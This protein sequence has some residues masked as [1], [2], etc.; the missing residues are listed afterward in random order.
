MLTTIIIFIIVFLIYLHWAEQYK[1]GEDLEIYEIDFTDNGHLQEVCK[2]K[3]PIVC[4]FSSV[5]SKFHFLNTISLDD[6]GDK[7][8]K[9]D[10]YVKDTDDTGSCDAIPLSLES[11]LKLMATDT[12]SH[13]ISE[14][15]SEFIDET[16]LEKYYDS[17]HEYIK[18]AFTIHKQ[19]DLC[20][21]SKG[22]S[23]PLRYNT[24]FSH[25]MYVPKGK[26]R[27]KMT[28]H[29]SKKYLHPIKDYFSYEFY[30]PVCVWNTQ[31]EYQ[32][33]IDKIQ[34][35]DF[36]VY[37][38]NLLF[39]PPYW[40]FSLQYEE[41]GTFLYSIKYNTLMNVIANTHNIGNY[42]FQQY[43]TKTKP[44]KVLKI[45]EREIKTEEINIPI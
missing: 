4:E 34:F 29:K 18:P 41:E 12:H 25:F 8:G 17:L 44:A 9:L 38:G 21:G 14:G 27:V 26:I 16:V 32:N 20:Y 11:S 42:L 7:Y 28:P 24:D 2:S 19:M 22:S 5:L 40:W 15:N 39:I 35:L 30:S 10:V 3:Q 43:T 23:T 1:S 45:D 33:T 36:D 6:L 37:A 31:S 13:Y